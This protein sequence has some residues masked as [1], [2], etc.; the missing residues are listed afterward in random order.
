MMATMDAA[1][2]LLDGSLPPRRTQ[3]ARIL[4]T[5][6]NK[7]SLWVINKTDLKQHAQWKTYHFSTAP[8]RI[9]VQTGSGMGHFKQR[10]FD[11]LPPS[12][13]SGGEGCDIR[14]NQVILLAK[15]AIME[16]LEGDWE[17]A[18]E[19]VAMELREASDA[20]GTLAGRIT[21]EEIL[22]EVFSRFCIGK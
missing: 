22:N 12:A 1:V 14:T 8:C 16:A 13:G 3:L 6:G 21:D 18:L 5:A 10:L 7:P 20:L 15:H 17:G 9:S 19:M 2:I 4:E 11:G